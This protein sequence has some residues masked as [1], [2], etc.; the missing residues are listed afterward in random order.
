L[1]GS[2]TTTTCALCALLLSA[3]AR[4]EPAPAPRIGADLRLP[5][6]IETIES[7][8]PAH[9][10]LD[11]LLRD[12]QLQEALVVRAVEAA[13]SVFNPRQ[14]RADR[15]YRLVRT[16][17]GEL[18]EFEY[19]IDT[20]TFLSIVNRDLKD[21]EALQAEVLAYDKVVDV[22]AIDARIDADHPSLIAAIDATGEN[23]QLAMALAEIFAGEVDFQSELQPGDSFRVLFEKT[24]HDGEFAGYGE[25]LGASIAV[26]HHAHEAFRWRDPSPGG[27]AG[28]YDAQGRS[29]KRFMLR[30]PLKFEPRVTSGFSLH[31][32]HPIDHVSRPHLGVDY[33]APVGAAVVAVAGGTV[34]SAGYSGASG[35]LVHLKHARG[36][37]TYYLHL[38]AFAK[39]IRAGAHVEQGQVIGRVGATGA[40]TGPHL[41]YRLK[42]DG[43]FV[44]P[45]AVHSK[46]APGEPIPT[47]QLVAFGEMRD[48][49]LAQLSTTLLASASEQKP[50][51]VKAQAR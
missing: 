31:R 11:G 37:E 8:V 28:F 51:A 6:E 5:A 46:Q 35:N 21:P 48:Q 27:K 25:I 26:D 3:C 43:T 12:N 22:V 1:R 2:G 16:F 4:Q 32:M 14:L 23:V 24:S 40:A 44:N 47:S 15:P 49:R 39:G 29:L 45:L 10:T 30:S 9:A 17:D 13:R 20:D 42:R 50:D 19:Q 36:I 41:D 33:A 18:R 38:S 34:V 7:R